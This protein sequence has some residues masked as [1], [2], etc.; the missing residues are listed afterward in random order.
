MDELG[1]LILDVITIVPAG[2]VV[3]FPSYN[4]IDHII[5]HWKNSGLIDQITKFKHIFIESRDEN[6][7]E[8]LQTYA[9]AVKEVDGS[10]V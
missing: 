1:L 10:K 7:D 4:Y 9:N 8:M 5:M 6:V 2:V 3:F